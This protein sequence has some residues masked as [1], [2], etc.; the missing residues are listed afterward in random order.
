MDTL[1]KARIQAMLNRRGLNEPSFYQIR[2][3]GVLG[4]KWAGWFEGLALTV[5]G[6]ETILAGWIPDQ[7]A[8]H[9]VL[10]KIRDLDLPLL[11]VERI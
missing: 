6:D 7:A 1:T 2:V 11:C 4:S 8:L 3:K 9:G 10:A 5:E